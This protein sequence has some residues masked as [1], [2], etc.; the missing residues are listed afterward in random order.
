M[1][2]DHMEDFGTGVAWDM[3]SPGA[4]HD[5]VTASITALAEGLLTPAFSCLD[6]CPAPDSIRPVGQLRR[7]W[8]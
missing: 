3:E 1:T 6:P 7:A 2:M 5:T 8:E 4:G